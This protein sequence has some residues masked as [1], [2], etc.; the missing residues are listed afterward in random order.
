MFHFQIPSG[1]KEAL[2]CLPWNISDL[3]ALQNLKTLLFLFNPCKIEFEHCKNTEYKLNVMGGK[4]LNCKQ[5][6]CD[7][8]IHFMFVSHLITNV[9][10]M[11]VPS[12]VIPIGHLQEREKGKETPSMCWIRKHFQRVCIYISLLFNLFTCVVPEI[13]FISQEFWQ[14]C[15]PGIWHAFVHK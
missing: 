7:V 6:S 10:D 1:K 12:T 3:N 15:E 4:V 2:T 13:F 14:A 8:T 9:C 5:T 11:A